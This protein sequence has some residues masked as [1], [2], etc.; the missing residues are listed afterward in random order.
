M[1]YHS[2]KMHDICHRKSRYIR[3]AP[4]DVTLST[5]E[6]GTLLIRYDAFLSQGRSSSD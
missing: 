3:K 6:R 5:S 1:E 4:A 2:A